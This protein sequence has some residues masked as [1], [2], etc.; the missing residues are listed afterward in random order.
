M[1]PAVRDLEAAGVA[2]TVNEYEH[3]PEARG[4]GIE[5]AEALGLDPD[6]VFKTLLVTADGEPAVAIVRRP[7]I[8][9]RRAVL[10]RNCESTQ[11]GLPP[12]ALTLREPGGRGTAARSIPWN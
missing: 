8:G 11:S 5:A 3:D 7:G 10:S 2:F 9:G 1:T 6:Q 4:Y 12:F